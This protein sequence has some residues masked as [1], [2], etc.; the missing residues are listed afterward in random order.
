M[1]RIKSKGNKSTELRIVRLLVLAGIK[2]WRRHYRLFGQPDFV[3]REKRVVVFVDGCFWH[4]HPQF[5]R[6]PRSNRAYWVRKIEKNKRRDREVTAYL[7][8]NGWTVL[9]I[10]E[11][12]L[13]HVNQ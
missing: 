10:W 12:E 3:F 13:R 7:K 5:C 1:A 9:R 4:G 11:H 2:G 6:I 8:E